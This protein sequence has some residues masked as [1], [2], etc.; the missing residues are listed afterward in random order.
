MIDKIEQYAALKFGDDKQAAAEFIEGF[1]K[2]AGILDGMLG[3]ATGQPVPS[4]K[5]DIPPRAPDTLQ[6]TILKGM[7]TSLGQGLGGLAITGSLTGLGTMYNKVH[8]MALHSK[9]LQALERAYQSNRIL[10][11]APREKVM[12]Y[13]ETIFRFAPNIST[14]SNILSSV[15]ANAIHGEGIY[16]DTIKMLTDIEDKYMGNSGFN[17]KMYS[18]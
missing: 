13:A 7:G 2:E 4:G 16:P 17:P 10:K 12:Q 11:E 15:L 14:D 5:P 8:N 3:A 1:T 9:F 6:H 18:K